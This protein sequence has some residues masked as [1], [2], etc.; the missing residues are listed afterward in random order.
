M[1]RSRLGVDTVVGKSLEAVGMERVGM[2][3]HV[4][5]VLV[6]EITVF[7]QKLGLDGTGDENVEIEL[8]LSDR[9]VH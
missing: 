6:F 1:G 3:A 4:L 7:P 9:P 5:R 8:G 2:A